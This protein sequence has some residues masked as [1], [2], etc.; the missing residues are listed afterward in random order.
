MR[1][2]NA[3]IKDKISFHLDI[4]NSEISPKIGNILSLSAD[5]KAKISKK[6]SFDSSRETIQQETPENNE[7]LIKKVTYAIQSAADAMRRKRTFSSSWEIAMHIMSLKNLGNERDTKLIREW[8][9]QLMDARNSEGVWYSPYNKQAS[10]VYDTSF[11]IV[12][13]IKSGEDPNSDIISNAINFI[14]RMNISLY[15]GWPATR[16][17]YLDVGATSW[18]II[19]LKKA[20]YVFRWDQIPGK[21]EGRLKEFLIKEFGIDWVNNARIEKIYNGMAI[22][23]STENNFLSIRL[24]DKKTEALLEIDNCRT[25]ILMAK[26]ENDYLST[27]KA[28]NNTSFI[29]RRGIEWLRLN[30]HQDGGWGQLYYNI[31]DRRP[32]LIAKTSDAVAALLAYGVDSQ[33][34]PA[35][36]DAINWLIK[37]HNVQNDKSIDKWA[38]SWGKDEN[39]V[40]HDVE[41]ASC[42]ILTLLKCKG[43]LDSSMG[44]LIAK[45][46]QLS[47]IWLLEKQNGD[48]TWEDETN[49]NSS[50]TPR[51]VM[52]LKYFS[53]VLDGNRHS[54]GSA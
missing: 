42:A 12:A 50:I 19:A 31:P 9:R 10:N 4:F 7:E 23:V 47:I 29:I 52:C 36:K 45:V 44:A 43:D 41:N 39:I 8:T 35:I 49:R 37:L 48:G 6:A 34:S 38:W 54:I 51:V 16:G 13:L 14:E 15:G 3:P 21:E 1:P 22:K 20:T 24:N 30:Q 33:T 2:E 18:A 11:A 28:P 32:S 27:Y 17:E 53:N 26:M 25:N 40:A 46:V 5:E